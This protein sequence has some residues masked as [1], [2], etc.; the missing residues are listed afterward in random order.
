[1]RETKVAH[2]FY[3]GLTLC[4]ELLTLIQRLFSSDLLRMIMRCLNLD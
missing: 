4:L 1:M 3:R 2:T